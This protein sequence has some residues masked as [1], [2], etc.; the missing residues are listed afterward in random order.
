MKVNTSTVEKLIMGA[1]LPAHDR[2]K[3]ECCVSIGIEGKSGKVWEHIEEI[4]LLECEGGIDQ[5]IQCGCYLA[6]NRLRDNVD[7]LDRDCVIVA[8]IAVCEIINT[9]RLASTEWMVSE[10]LGVHEW[11]TP[12][13]AEGEVKASLERLKDRLDWSRLN[14]ARKQES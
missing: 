5:H 4:D 10:V 7:N 3:L 11:Q 14:N 12:A 6:A 9:R 8:V 1:Y 13:E 2:V